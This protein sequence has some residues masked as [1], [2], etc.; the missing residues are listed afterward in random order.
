MMISTH[1]NPVI[2]LKGDQIKTKK[3]VVKGKK[4]IPRIGMIR[5]L[6]AE[7]N[8]AGFKSHH[9]IKAA[10]GP[11]NKNIVNIQHIFSPFKCG[12]VLNIFRILY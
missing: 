3:S 10:R 12:K 11:R 4:M 8:L 7:A 2:S 5:L 6:K 1:P 9:R